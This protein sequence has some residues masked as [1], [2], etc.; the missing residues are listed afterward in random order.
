[1]MRG[2][3]HLLGF[4]A[5]TFA[6]EAFDRPL[7]CVF[8]QR[9]PATCLIR[10]FIA[11]L[12]QSLLTLRTAWPT[13]VRSPDHRRMATALGASLIRAGRNLGYPDLEVEMQEITHRF[14]SAIIRFLLSASCSPRV[15]QCR[16]SIRAVVWLDVGHR[17][18]L[19][20]TFVIGG[21]LFGLLHL[22][23]RLGR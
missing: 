1:M 14:S 10:A 20:A 17:P 3:C 8:R 22:D 4:R 2:L 6:P 23:V 12:D 5:A 21:L 7:G 9:H 19:I 11:S 13:A 18:V 16:P 15:P